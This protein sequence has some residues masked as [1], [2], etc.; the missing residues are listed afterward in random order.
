VAGLWFYAHVIGC[1]T[2]TFIVGS[3]THAVGVLEEED[4]LAEGGREVNIVLGCYGVIVVV[5]C[6]SCWCMASL[7]G[8]VS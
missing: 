2:A 3:V 1:A 4:L 8:R 7:V 6:A 5:G